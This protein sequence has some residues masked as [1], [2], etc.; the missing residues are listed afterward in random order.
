MKSR[1][2]FAAVAICMLSFEMLWLR[3]P[4]VEARAPG[5]VDIFYSPQQDL[6]KIDAELIDRATRSIDMAAYLLTSWPVMKALERAAD[7]GVKIRVVL[8][9]SELQRDQSRSF[10]MLIERKGVEVRVKASDE[11]M[12]LKS[13]CVDGRW[14]RGGSANFTS[15]GLQRQDNDLWS[16]DSPEAA[17]AFGRKFEMLFVGGDTFQEAATRW[18][19][20]G[21]ISRHRD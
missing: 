15:S 19:P 17:A 1:L 10:Q 11:L 21:W 2:A 20:Q 8:E 6:Q 16:V 12:N 7:R 3:A 18:P 5:A 14:V 9:A 13:F 4:D